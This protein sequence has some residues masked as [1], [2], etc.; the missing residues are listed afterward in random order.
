MGSTLLLTGCVQPYGGPPIGSVAQPNSAMM[1][2][3]Q[4]ATIE[5]R[6]RVNRFQ[7]L[8]DMYGT[9]Q[10]SVDQLTLPPGSV[11][12]MSGPVPVVRVVFPERAFFAFDSATPL[13][14]SE[15]IFD[16]I[17]ENMKHDVPDAAL[18]VL[19][20]T[21]AIGTDPY[22]IGLSRRRAEAVMAA[23]VA[24]GVSADQLS[25]VAI[26]KRQPIAPNETAAGRAL[27]RRVEFLIS[28]AMTANL[29]AVQ[30]RVVPQSFFATG[31]AFNTVHPA[32]PDIRPASLDGGYGVPRLATVYRMRARDLDAKPEALSDDNLMAVGNLQLAPASVEAVHTEAVTASTTTAQA[33]NSVH[34]VS[35]QQ[36]TPVHLQPLQNVSPRQLDSNPGPGTY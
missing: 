16:V 29:A 35:L 3:D 19:G 2:Q 17:A 11:D 28:P 23:L 26:G 21:D 32:S 15:P 22:N 27:N 24:R 25:E 4:T 13:P 34:L 30:Q 36:P 10:P 12:F 6:D 33:M 5:E 1:S 20:H 9:V 8:A 14:S 18:T 7:R 31:V